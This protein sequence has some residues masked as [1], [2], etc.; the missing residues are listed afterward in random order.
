MEKTAGEAGRGRQAEQPT[1]IPRA[2]WKD[3]LIRA[4]KESKADQLALLAAGV[5]FYAMLALFPTLI[6]LVTIY[7]LV[8]DPAQIETLLQ[9]YASALPPQAAALL[10]DQIATT[11]GARRGLTIGLVV[12]LLGVLWSASGGVNGLITGINLTYDEDETRG[13][14]KRRGVALLLTLSAIVLA[15]VVIVLLAVVPVV[16]NVV[17]LGRVA[18]LAITALR[19][20]LLAVLVMG[21][22][23]VLYRYA[24]DRNQARFAWVSPG[25]LVATLL[26][27]AGS[28]T[29]GVYVRN[30]GR[31]D[32]TYGAIGGV[33][34]LLLWLFVSAFAVL[35]GAELNAETERQ[36]YRDSTRGPAKPLGQRGAYAADT[37][38]PSQ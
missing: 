23:A 8:A 38:G 14:V 24:P 7:G 17:G 36:T 4:V 26:W 33:I 11:T 27:L 22:L 9:S 25:A 20:P 37:V 15:V 35:F 32:Q 10:T 6:A 2:G 12:S 1:Q 16:L 19:W 31:Y 18:E 21:A 30:F 13:F 34:V 3:I 5:A 28:A 29:F